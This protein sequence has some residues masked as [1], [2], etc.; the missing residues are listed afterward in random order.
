MREG[1]RPAVA[2]DRPVIEALF[3]AATEELRGERGGDVW[4]RQHDRDAGF[5][6]PE[7]HGVDGVAFVG[8]VDDVVVGYAVV[9]V[10]TMEDGEDLAVIDDIYVEPAARSVAVGELLLDAAVAWARA[11]GC[12]GIDALALPGMRETKNFFE[13]AGLTARAI[14]VHKRLA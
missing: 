5:R 1:A 3:R 13:S 6:P 7:E 9:R 11:R 8:T 4:A 2:E 12:T 14:I 10:E